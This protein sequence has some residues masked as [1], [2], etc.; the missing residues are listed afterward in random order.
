MTTITANKPIKA[1]KKHNISG[2]LFEL[3]ETK[4]HVLSLRAELID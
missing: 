2:T 3:C 1:S 4:I